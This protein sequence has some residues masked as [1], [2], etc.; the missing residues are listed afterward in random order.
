MVGH[1]VG[2]YQ[3]QLRQVIGVDFCVG[4]I[5]AFRELFVSFRV[6]IIVRF[7]LQVVCLDESGKRL[8][9]ERA[10]RAF[11]QDVGVALFRDVVLLVVQADA[12][13]MIDLCVL[14]VGLAVDALALGQGNVVVFLLQGIP[15]EKLGELQIVGIL[16]GLL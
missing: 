3:G 6:G 4:L 14:V 11:V 1:D 12:R 2:L 10:A 13:K 8:A 16:L 9:I 7:Q 5:N 15:N